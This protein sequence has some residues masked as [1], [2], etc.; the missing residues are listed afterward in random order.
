M[1]RENKELGAMPTCYCLTLMCCQACLPNFQCCQSCVS[2][3]PF[4]I[5]FFCYVSNAVVSGTYPS[6][7]GRIL[8]LIKSDYHGWL[9]S[10][11]DDVIWGPPFWFCLGP[12]NPKPI[13]AYKIILQPSIS[14]VKSVM[15]LYCCWLHSCWLMPRI[16]IFR[17]CLPQ[18]FKAM[19]STATR[20]LSERC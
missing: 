14:G 13:T 10:E 3:T 8:G 17:L 12:P 15:D 19:Q 5:F 1:G 11:Y 2:L 6:L 4:F 16:A 20:D 9:R 7:G 18:L